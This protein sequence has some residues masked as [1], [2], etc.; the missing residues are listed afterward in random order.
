MTWPWATC[1]RVL[2]A[3]LVFAVLQPLLCAGDVTGRVE[4][5]DAHGAALR[6]H[7]D[8]S[9]V[10]V[11]LRPAEPITPVALKPVRAVITQKNKTFTPHILAIPVG[12]T[13]SFPNLDPIFHN[14]FSSYN[15]QIFD[16]GLYAPGTTRS[17]TFTR[18]GVVRVFC[19]IH[20]SMSAMIVVLNAPYF[21]LSQRDGGFRIGD[22]PPG[23]YEMR[24]I[25]ERA[26]E[27]SL[28]ALSRRIKVPA[29]GLALPSLKISETGRSA[30]PHKDKYGHDY[31]P[32]SD[33]PM[34][35]P[36]TR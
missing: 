35:Y 20:S 24:L 6:P 12:S 13:V 29:E 3:C 31:R 10:V 15:G 9:G 2:P 36:E 28:M 8:S 27:A 30:P 21:A 16:L 23:D 5:V 22:V 1:F 19:N 14:A 4:L 18:E 32:D 7:P 11:S 25:H 17:V 26:T 34:G 33:D